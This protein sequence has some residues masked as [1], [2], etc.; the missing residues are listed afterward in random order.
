MQ[1]NVFE[2]APRHLTCLIRTV[3]GSLVAE[4]NAHR[5]GLHHRPVPDLLATA[6]LFQGL[7]PTEQ[8][9]TL[10]NFVGGFMSQSAKH[11]A[12]LTE[13]WHCQRCGQRDS[14]SHRLF[15]CPATAHARQ[16]H[17]GALQEIQQAWPHWAHASFL[18]AHDAE[19]FLRLVHN[20]RQLPAPAQV[21]TQ[22]STT[23]LSFYT[24]GSCLCPSVPSAARAGWAVIL[25][26]TQGRG[27]QDA[28]EDPSE[29]PTFIAGALQVLAT[30]LVPGH[31]SPDRAE[32]AALVQALKAA[33][34]DHCISLDVHSDCQYVVRLAQ[35]V[36]QFLLT[37]PPAPLANQDL[38]QQLCEAW[39]PHCKVHKVQAHR[40]LN[41]IPCPKERWRALANDAADKAAKLALEGELEVVRDT[42][43]AIETWH[44]DQQAHLVLFTR[45]LV[46]LAFAERQWDLAANTHGPDCAPPQDTPADTSLVAYWQTVAHQHIA[47][48]HLPTPDEQVIVCSTW[49]A[50]FSWALWQWASELK[51]PSHPPRDSSHAI[52]WAELFVNFVVV[53]GHL[54]S[55]P[56]HLPGDTKQP[57][58]LDH[59]DPRAR[60][61]PS[62]ARTVIHSFVAAVDHLSR[63]AGLHLLCGPRL[64]K[65]TS[66]QA[67]GERQDRKGLLWRPEMPRQQETYETIV[68]LLQCRWTLEAIRAAQAAA[69]DTG[70]YTVPENLRSRSTVLTYN[71]RLER[72]RAVRRAVPRQG[73]G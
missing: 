57:T 7:S 41:T 62:S 17:M 14:K 37:G 3:W 4:W 24:D 30:G 72:Q 19:P 12:R 69:Q 53:T 18:Q 15:T 36:P 33:A 8:K 27:F 39:L 38:L 10:R 63:L 31:Q 64:S 68:G 23:Q 21:P 54:P 35:L 42:A 6:K 28:P 1:F 47:P 43:Q 44:R 20:T 25:D 52:S 66:L 70:R 58:Y 45:F 55:V 22:Y 73:I 71:Q 11:A 5:N 61:A 51:W 48:G 60:M 13:D 26:R 46:D 67:L 9:C 2:V 56:F 16:G 59:D 40:A 32:L 65:V 34:T 29:W 50:K 49:G